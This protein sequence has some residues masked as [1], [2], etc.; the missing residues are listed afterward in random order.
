MVI[1]EGNS[2]SLKIE[3]IVSE[4]YKIVVDDNLVPRLAEFA[5][6]SNFGSRY[7]ILTDSN[8]K[9]YAIAVR[10]ALRDAG[11]AADAMM[12]PAGEQSKTVGKCNQIWN[13]L[14]R[15]KYGRDSVIIGVGGGVVTD[16]AG[17]IAA[18]YTREVPCILY[19][20]SLLAMVDAAIGGKTGVDLEEG[21]N[22]VGR[23]QQP[24]AVFCD[25]A[26]LKD[27]P[28]REF[29]NG[30]AEVVKY[31]FIR[32]EPLFR[33]LQQNVE[34]IL[35]KDKDCVRHIVME[36]C[37]IKSEIVEQDPNEKGLRRILNYGH[38]PAHPLEKL[39]G[40]N[41]AEMP[42][43][44]AVSICMNV[45][46]RIS[47]EMRFLSHGELVQQIQLLERF[48]LPVRIPEKY[49]NEDIIALTVIDKKS[50]NGRARYTLPKRIGEMCG[51]DGAYV[52]EVDKEIVEKALNDTR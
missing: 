13:E 32:D 22:M 45:A 2:L 5:K 34:K 25:T 9:A 1:I 33:Y 28:D 52:T 15:Q 23:I 17:W 50:A 51:F 46:A 29:V 11:L 40:F 10:S 27:L 6:N 16:M 47:K 41:S 37:R 36:S 18:N 19:P 12:I 44:F 4:S 14:A 3:R 49:K 43:G 39:A 7:A 42:H 26:T 20:T 48:G 38:T 31:G 24:K 21:K 8:T 30:L 35:A